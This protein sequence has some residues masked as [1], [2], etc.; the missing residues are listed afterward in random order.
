MSRYRK[1]LYI[2]TGLK[3]VRGAKTAVTR[4][5]RGVG[6]QLGVEV[7]GTIWSG[8][9]VPLGGGPELDI[10]RSKSQEVSWKESGDFVLAYR[11][12]KI[13]VNKRTNG[14]TR[15]EDYIKGAMLGVDSQGISGDLIDIS[16]GE[17]FDLEE[18]DWETTSVVEGDEMLNIAMPKLK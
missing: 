12:R 6:A 10:G 11:V 9:T 8:G 3:I 5:E 7:D 16:D 17:Q 14:V 2:I 13:K 4:R 15:D 18:Q 1:P